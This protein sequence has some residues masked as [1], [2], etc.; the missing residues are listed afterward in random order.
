MRRTHENFRHNFLALVVDGGRL[1]HDCRDPKHQEQKR[2]HVEQRSEVA[3]FD[4][5]GKQ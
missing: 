3:V 2:V 1:H 5:T 4:G